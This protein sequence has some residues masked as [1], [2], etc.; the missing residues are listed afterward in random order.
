MRG[1]R[2]KVM[3]AIE[4]HLKGPEP[5]SDTQLTGPVFDSTA[6]LQRDVWQEA[7]DHME[8]FA[9]TGTNRDLTLEQQQYLK[10]LKVDRYL[11][12]TL[13]LEF[14]LLEGWLRINRRHPESDHVAAFLQRRE[15]FGP[16]S[17]IEQQ[18]MLYLW[19]LRNEREALA[20]S[21]LGWRLLGE[22][23]ADSLL[24][25]ASQNKGDRRGQLIQ[26]WQDSH[27]FYPQNRL[28]VWALR[29]LE[30]ARAPQVLV[31][32]TAVIHV[33]VETHPELLTGSR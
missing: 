12:A 22:E 13:E 5:V 32:E 8:T 1:C 18:E 10:D 26:L 9:E 11:H 25:W 7:L 19:A 23:L 24:A 15:K 27:G 33:I 16:L 30:D 2:K 14:G 31:W 21:I 20:S 17:R 29:F 3:D 4:K 28:R 6:L